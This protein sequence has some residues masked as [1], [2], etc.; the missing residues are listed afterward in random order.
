MPDIDD[1]I[2]RL[3]QS[4]Q[5]SRWLG[6]L[7]GSLPQVPVRTTLPTASEDFAYRLI[8][9]EDTPSVAYLC[10]QDGAGAWE[11]AEV[12]SGTP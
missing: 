1:R 2:D 9:I 6:P 8:V 5:R 11:W 4:L 10:L 12:A 7:Y 3:E